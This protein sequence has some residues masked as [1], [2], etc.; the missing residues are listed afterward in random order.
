MNPLAAY[1]LLAHGLIFGALV[2]L[3]PLGFLRARAGLAATALALLVG[4]APTLHAAFGPPSITLLAL[5]LLQLFNPEQAS[6]L[7]RPAAL[8][9]LLPGTALYVLSLSGLAVDPY[10]VGYQPAP[11]LTA[12]LAIGLVLWW[13]RH[14]IWLAILAADLLAYASGVFSNLW[15]VL[16]DPLLLLAAMSLLLR[17]L[18][19]RLARLIAPGRR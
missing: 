6:P 1:G 17:P 3:L 5:G 7:T 15:D 8:A 9:L 10:A 11:L 2:T 18:S 4:I 16:I 14:F 19:G 12:L 13:R